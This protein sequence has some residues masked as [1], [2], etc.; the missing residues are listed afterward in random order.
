MKSTI[1]INE[2][3][4]VYNDNCVLDIKELK[5][6]ERG[7][8]A[9]IGESGCGKTTLMNILGLL[10]S[11][12]TGSLSLFGKTLDKFEDDRC[13]DLRKKY[14]G[15]MFQDDILFNNIT[16]RDNIIYPL[17][18]SNVENYEKDVKYIAQL[19]EIEEYLD[20]YP[21]ELSRGQRQ[22]VA[23]ARA[24][25]DDKKVILAD[26][27]TGNLDAENSRIIFSYLKKLSEEKLVLI[28]T[29][30]L[31]L[32]QEFSD[33][34]IKL[35]DG[36]IVN[37]YY[38]RTNDYKEKNIYKEEKSYTK[39]GNISL[40][41][42]HAICDVRS[43]LKNSRKVFLS[44][45]LMT[46]ILVLTIS[47]FINS[48]KTLADM[49]NKYFGKNYICLSPDIEYN[50]ETALSSRYSLGHY[51]ED[52]SFLD[53]ND[54]EEYIKYY[55]CSL[56]IEKGLESF[57]VSNMTPVKINDYFKTKINYLG[58]EG[59]MLSDE[60]DIILASDIAEW[61][62]GETYKDNLGDSIEGMAAFG[63]YKF[64]IVGFNTKKDVNG[65]IQTYITEGAMHE[66]ALNEARLACDNDA[67]SIYGPCSYEVSPNNDSNDRQVYMI[68][69]EKMGK[70][71]NNQKKIKALIG[72][73]PQKIDEAMIST[74]FLKENGKDLFG[75]IID[76]SNIASVD[77]LE[78]Y[79][80][81]NDI[82]IVFDYSG[83]LNKVKIIGVFDDADSGE[84]IVSN[85][86][87]EQLKTVYPYQIDA[88]I[89]EKADIDLLMKDLYKKGFL[90]DRPYENY[91]DGI[92]E[93]FSMLKMIFGV[94]AV[95]ILLVLIVVINTFTSNN[96]RNHKKDIGLFLAMGMHVKD[97]R[98]VYVFE[99]LLIGLSTEIFAV[100]VLC[101]LRIL[102]QTINTQ[103]PV[104]WASLLSFN[105]IEIMFS[106]LLSVCVFSLAA[107]PAVGKNTRLT[108]K[109]AIYN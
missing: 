25:I 12:S 101:G 57:P 40:F 24:V 63:K 95:I 27:P 54:I 56:S 81:G 96:I 48:R 71:I 98:K 83:A 105:G 3:T 93:R 2:V 70:V 43:E 84:I 75:L 46:I 15:Y 94:I 78:K 39:S 59:S 82:Y 89:N 1:E 58:I 10:D 31:E 90:C 104:S 91:K 97:I 9:I 103:N 60:N 66:I 72:K 7:F 30:N 85:E 35:V 92:S 45:A 33:R 77:F 21:H 19:F 18:I 26:E 74:S 69:E 100:V 102:L 51:M 5:L 88:F 36:K 52:V 61:Y 65:N 34:I 99:S 8:V 80:L 109:E 22:R 44:G 49:E 64:R 76:D 16:V 68:G 28:A 4:K 55:E 29:H 106:V 41:V 23:L 32:A 73:E 38:K 6:P 14:I 42:K 62:Y 79:V 37:D 13:S 108:P 53:N 47:T 20:R 17:G 11:A 107:I 67:A 50:L 86:G 87:L